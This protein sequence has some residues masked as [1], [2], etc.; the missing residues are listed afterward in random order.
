M[1]KQENRKDELL[2]VA[3][4]ARLAECTE[5]SIRYQLQAGKLTRYE[6]GTGKVRVSQN[7]ILDKVINFNLKQK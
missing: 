7:E 2:T 3:Q 6:N 1:E 5:N 4:A